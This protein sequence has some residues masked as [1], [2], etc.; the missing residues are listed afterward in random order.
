MP[1][2]TS[3][4]GEISKH[5]YAIYMCTQ[6][7]IFFVIDVVVMRQFNEGQMMMMMMIKSI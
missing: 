5:V 6:S 2:G 1:K 4:V 7:S 3:I